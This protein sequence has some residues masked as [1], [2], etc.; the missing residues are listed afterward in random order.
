MWACSVK[1][2]FLVGFY[3]E[4]WF[5]A[6]VCLI[7]F[8]VRSVFLLVRFS[9]TS[10]YFN[11]VP[12][13][14]G[15]R[16]YFKHNLLSHWNS[17]HWVQLFSNYL[18]ASE[19]ADGSRAYFGG[20]INYVAVYEQELN[21]NQLQLAYRIGQERNHNVTLLRPLHLVA[22]TLE[23]TVLVQGRT[24]GQTFAIGGFNATK[25]GSWI[26][27]VEITSP[28]LFGSLRSIHGPALHPGV[29][30]PLLGTDTKTMM[31][32]EAQSPDFF[33]VPSS[34]YSGTG[35]NLPREVFSYRI[36]AVD[37]K[38]GK[39]VLGESDDVSKTLYILHVNHPPV[40]RYSSPL[41]IIQDG[42]PPSGVRSRPKATITGLEL[43]DP[44]L[45]ID[46]VRVDIWSWNGTVTV[47]DEYRPLV[48]FSSCHDRVFSAWQCLGDGIANRNMTFLAEPTDA[49][50][51]LSNIQYDAFSWN[52]RDLIVVRVFD[53]IGGPC[54]DP[55]EHQSSTE[56]SYTFQ[57]FDDP[58]IAS[59]KTL[60]ENCYQV[61]ANIEIPPL[62]LPEHQGEDLVGFAGFDKFQSTHIV[63]WVTV[64]AVVLA[65]CYCIPTCIKCSAR[66]GR[67]IFPDDSHFIREFDQFAT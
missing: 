11:G 43:W 27:Y 20:A 54:L 25:A 37:A 35:L 9:Q 12:I 51:I 67:R 18:D 61:T 3:R 21:E 7:L 14:D 23:T 60:H 58:E 30:I 64:S 39:T 57:M 19:S 17:K 66:R 8:P 55:S 15:A 13:I 48:D 62:G 40:L 56:S 10:V 46:R 2:I 28:P 52:S 34:S 65:L 33:T 32:Y 22:S 16:N 5:V 26:V 44:D 49:A 59:F 36:V 6:I 42:S 31:L 47:Q 4:A 50:L 45:N 1:F 29:R 53:G 24:D 63:F 41:R 38:T